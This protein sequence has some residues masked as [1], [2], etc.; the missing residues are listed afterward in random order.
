MQGNRHLR[1]STRQIRSPTRGGPKGGF[2]SV[3]SAR[4]LRVGAL[5][6]TCPRRKTPSAHR[7]IE[8]LS[9]P[10]EHGEGHLP[11]RPCSNV[12]RRHLP[13]CVMH[14]ADGF[15]QANEVE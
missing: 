12:A 7:T 13:T 15:G 2:L 1:W 3:E 4:M 10:L 11:A 8:R 9:T 5:P 6:T 14:V